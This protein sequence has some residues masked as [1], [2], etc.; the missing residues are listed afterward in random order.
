MPIL[1][2]NG[3]LYRPI[4]N[5][6]YGVSLMYSHKTLA[7]ALC[8]AVTGC[9]QHP[10]NA[11][12]KN[13]PAWWSFGGSEKAADQD[14]KKA[15]DE[16]VA[17]ADAKSESESHWWW[18]FGDSKK[19]DAPKV[20]KMPDPKVA[21]AWLDNYEPRLREAI[22]DSK[23]ELERRDN[24][25]VIT[26]PVDSSFNPDRPAMLLP[27][28]LGP[29][30][31]VAKVI[32]ADPK[33]AVLVVGHGD[34]GGATVANQKLSQER[35]QAVAAIFRLSGLQRDRLM[36]RG[37][38]SVMPRA[39]NDNQ[40]G[41]SLNRRVEM[42]LTPQDTMVAL[43]SKYN[44]PAPSPAELVA[45]QDA[46]APAKAA[47]KPSSKTPAKKAVAAKKTVA[48]KNTAAKKKAAVTKAATKPV[49]KK[50]PVAKDVAAAGTAKSN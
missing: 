14:V 34:T 35:A 13:D 5:P 16:K 8:L 44:Q 9:A 41:R 29:I 23:F 17:K 40:K 19:V 3:P 36:L 15:I 22:K 49:T 42:L 31:K 45:V 11:S 20:S 7:L 24:A 2:S 30:T 32:E 18:P 50:A 38:G 10:Q 46:K 4:L 25:L 27:V 28:T 47:A 1:L 48:A 33:T 6:F 26:A 37:M 12:A 43:L 39:A 21:Q